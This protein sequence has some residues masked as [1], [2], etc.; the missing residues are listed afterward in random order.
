VA[1]Y[2][3]NFTC[4]S[5]CK[6]HF[7]N[8]PQPQKVC[9]CC[10]TAA[11]HLEHNLRRKD[12]LYLSSIKHHAGTCC[13]QA[14]WLHTFLC[15]TLGEERRQ[16]HITTTVQ[17]WQ[18]PP[19]RSSPCTKWIQDGASH[20]AEEKTN[21]FSSHLGKSRLLWGGFLKTAIELREKSK[22]FTKHKQHNFIRLMN[23]QL[24]HKHRKLG[25]EKCVKNSLP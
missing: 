9:G 16:L 15:S 2:R 20:R 21:I 6:F 13:R 11:K 19:S 25:K 1:V 23:R 4:T 7:N 10:P 22:H 5:I 14:D 18:Y 24:L 3:V 12:K 8:I 17:P